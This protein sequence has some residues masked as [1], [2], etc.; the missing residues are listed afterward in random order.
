[1]EINGYLF[2]DDEESKYLIIRDKDV[3]DNNIANTLKFIEVQKID[4]FV[5]GDVDLDLSKYFSVL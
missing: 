1:M 3:N 4:C 2:R 5:L